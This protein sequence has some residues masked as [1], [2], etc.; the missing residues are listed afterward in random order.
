M[1]QIFAYNYGNTI[2]YNNNERDLEKF[3]Y[4][5]DF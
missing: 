5:D 3:L 4:I 1:T 2:I